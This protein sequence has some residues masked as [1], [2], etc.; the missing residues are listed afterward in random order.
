MD[1]LPGQG[2]ET[3]TWENYRLLSAKNISKKPI[4]ME[5]V[6]KNVDRHYMQGCVDYRVLFTTLVPRPQQKLL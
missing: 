5:V 4:K 1:F 2:F 6:I 3:E